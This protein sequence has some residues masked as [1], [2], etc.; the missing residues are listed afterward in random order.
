MSTYYIARPYKIND[1]GIP[2]ATEEFGEATSD[3][4]L[5]LK[6][7]IQ[8]KSVDIAKNELK[9]DVSLKKGDKITIY[10]TNGKDTVIFKTSDGSYVGLKYEKSFE[11]NGKPTEETFDGAVFAG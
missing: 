6:T 2:E 1:K 7:D 10:R 5:T 3:I 8:A 11:F 4:T 9:D